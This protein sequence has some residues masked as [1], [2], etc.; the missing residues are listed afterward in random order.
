MK[1]AFQLCDSCKKQQIC[2]SGF[3]LFIS[4]CGREIEIRTCKDY[5]PLKSATAAPPRKEG[6]R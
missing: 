1:R 2:P 3:A 4:E 6:E 5:D